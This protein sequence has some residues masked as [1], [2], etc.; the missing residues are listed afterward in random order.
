MV[1][2]AR[3]LLENGQQPVIGKQIPPFSS[4]KVL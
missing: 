2:V 3:L 4:Q 1:G